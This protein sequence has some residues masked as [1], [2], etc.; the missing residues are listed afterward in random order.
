MVSKTHFKF[1]TCSCTFLVTTLANTIIQ[2]RFNVHS[3]NGKRTLTLIL[4]L[5]HTSYN[6]VLNYVN[7]NV[8]LRNGKRTLRSIIVQSDILSYNTQLLVNVHSGM[9]THGTFQCRPS[10]DE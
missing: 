2:L 3:G 5:V 6:T 4:V 10:S 9:E 1:H 7:D 8:H